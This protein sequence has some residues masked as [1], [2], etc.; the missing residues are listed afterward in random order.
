MHQNGFVLY[1]LTANRYSRAA[2]P[3]RSFILRFI[4]PYQVN[5]L[6]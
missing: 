2:L 1:A 6:G 5:R 3:A 4:K